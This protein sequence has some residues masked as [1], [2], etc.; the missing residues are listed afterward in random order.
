VANGRN[1][2][3]K[4]DSGRD[5]GGFVALPWFVLDCPAYAAL[6]HSARGLL[7]EFARQFVRDNN[8]RL[9]CSYAYLAKRGWKSKDVITRAKNELLMAGFIFET[10][11]G[12]RPNKASWFAVTWRRLD[13]LPG[14]DAG[15]AAGF[16]RS[17]YMKHVPIKKTNRSPPDRPKRCAI[18]PSDRSDT[19]PSSPSDGSIKPV[20]SARSSPSDGHHLDM[21]SVR[22]K[23]TEIKG[24]TVIEI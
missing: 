24:I 19:E 2:G 3:K 12:M 11:K 9:L 7:L 17:A 16:E 8:G 4:G 20:S 21:P 10:V 5:A 18:G 22:A 6:S 23:Q 14:Y 15:A 13:K 1:I